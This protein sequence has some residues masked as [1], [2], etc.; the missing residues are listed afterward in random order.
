MCWQV[1]GSVTVV[2]ICDHKV[3][4]SRC[5]PSDERRW[6][7]MQSCKSPVESSRSRNRELHEQNFFLFLFRGFYGEAS[8]SIAFWPKHLR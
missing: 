5:P 2:V 3:V 8:A 7:S 4:A 6:K 1:L